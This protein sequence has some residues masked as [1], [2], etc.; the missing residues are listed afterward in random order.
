[1]FILRSKSNKCP[2]CDT[3]MTRSAEWGGVLNNI[4]IF[5]YYDEECKL[6]Y[7][8]FGE[9]MSLNNIPLSYRFKW[10]IDIED[11]PNIASLRK[12][13]SSFTDERKKEIAAVFAKMGIPESI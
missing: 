5:T 9:K 13:I 4:G 10:N 12:R 8:Y 6:P 11:C 7:Q 2:D 1:M 3:C